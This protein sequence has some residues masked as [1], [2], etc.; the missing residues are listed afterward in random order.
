MLTTCLHVFPGITA[1]YSKYTFSP[2]YIDVYNL[3]I[4]TYLLFWLLYIFGKEIDNKNLLDNKYYWYWNIK[5]NWSF[6]SSRNRFSKYTYSD[7]FLR[8]SFLHF[9]IHISEIWIIITW[10]VKMFNTSLCNLFLAIGMCSVSIAGRIKRTPKQ[11]TGQNP[12]ICRYIIIRVPSCSAK[13]A[14]LYS[15]IRVENLKNKTSIQMS[16]R[17]WYQCLFT[18]RCTHISN[19]TCKNSEVLTS[20]HNCSREEQNNILT[21]IKNSV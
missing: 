9:M 12:S 15:I 19:K 8:N 6:T 14:F 7:L 20:N 17:Q 21:H 16:W 10:F 3:K 2:K 5:K 11:E 4:Y 13:M 18:S 1:S